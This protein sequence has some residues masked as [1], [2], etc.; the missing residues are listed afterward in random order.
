MFS[1]LASRSCAT[2]AMISLTFEEKLETAGNL[3]HDQR[4]LRIVDSK[5]FEFN[6][7]N[8]IPPQPLSN[9]I[10]TININTLY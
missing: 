3:I 7:E 8:F 4:V 5:C 6:C 9:D 2:C 10:R 1:L